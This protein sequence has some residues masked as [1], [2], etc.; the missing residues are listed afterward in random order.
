[1]H[2][3][4]TTHPASLRMATPAPETP[5]Y[6]RFHNS[7]FCMNAIDIMVTTARQYNDGDMVTTEW[8]YNDS[9]RRVPAANPNH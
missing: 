6:T 9:D 2:C 1:M 5:R 3:Q 7:W 4:H 8:L